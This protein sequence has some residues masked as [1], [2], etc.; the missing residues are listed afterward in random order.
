MPDRILTSR[1][2]S[3][4]MIQSAGGLNPA[5]DISALLS[6][7]Q[8]QTAFTD[9]VPVTSQNTRNDT[10]CRPGSSWPASSPATPPAPRPWNRHAGHHHAPRTAHQGLNHETPWH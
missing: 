2:G 3:L 5:A 10:P 7:S 8:P 1:A 6:S 4:L 9:I